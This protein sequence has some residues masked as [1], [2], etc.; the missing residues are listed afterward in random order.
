MLITR[1]AYFSD[2]LFD[3]D[4]ALWFGIGA[5]AAIKGN[6]LVH[7]NLIVRNSGIKD[8]FS[9]VKHG[10]T[11]ALLQKSFSICTSIAEILWKLP[12]S[13]PSFLF[14]PKSSAEMYFSI[15]LIYTYMYAQ[16]QP[17]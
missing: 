7:R 6:D 13:G 10:K 5:E 12:V 3:S 9:I 16:I 8:K 17:L 4:T 11:A 1:T 14:I 15:F 2:V